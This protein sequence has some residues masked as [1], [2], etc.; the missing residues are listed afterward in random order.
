VRRSFHFALAVF[1]GFAAERLRAV[2][3]FFTT[4]VT[5]PNLLKLTPVRTSG[6]CPLQL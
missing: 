2:D 1:G 3:F 6:N 4:V 5:T